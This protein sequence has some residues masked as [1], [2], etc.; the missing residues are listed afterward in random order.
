MASTLQQDCISEEQQDWLFPLVVI[1]FT[2]QQ[3][4]Y[5]QIYQNLL[6]ILRLPIY[7]VNPE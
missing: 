4:H 2:S 3:N 1:S 6:I 5:H 7:H